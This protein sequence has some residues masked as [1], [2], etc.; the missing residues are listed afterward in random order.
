M[1][2]NPKVSVC[3]MTYNH[4]RFIAQAIESVLEQK[5]VFDFEL[6]IGEDCSTD[7]TR[8]IVAEYARKY[9]EKIRAMFRE[10]NLGM[11]ANFL[12]TLSECRGHYIALLEGDDYWTDPLKLQKQVDF[13]D[14]H[15]LYSLCCH[16]YKIYDEESKN[17][18]PDDG[19]Q[20]LFADAGEGK[21]ITVD[22]FFNYRIDWLIHPLTVVFRKEMLDIGISAKYKH[23]S[24]V[25]LFY[26][27]IAKG[28]GRRFNFIGGVYRRHR[29]GIFSKKS[30]IE[31]AEW[32]YLAY[33]ELYEAC[34]T[35]FIKKA[36][37]AAYTNFIYCTIRNTKRPYLKKS[38]YYNMAKLFLLSPGRFIMKAMKFGYYSFHLDAVVKKWE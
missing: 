2:E 6:V 4:E 18:D 32:I 20:T 27:L 22:I 30:A 5:T 7:G 38:L 23:F 29:G 10:T 16:C 34:T 13:L 24:D 25:P 21:D 28:K 31:K 14:V 15:P 37:L 35:P 33:K 8:K 36:Y 17:W 1:S 9:P 12:Q 26:H 19:N 11:T 3:M